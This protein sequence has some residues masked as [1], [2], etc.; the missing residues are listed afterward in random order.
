ML[1]SSQNRTILDPSG[2]VRLGLS[3]TTAGS[4]LSQWPIGV[5]ETTR[6][7]TRLSTNGTGV[8]AAADYD[9]DGKADLALWRSGDSTFYS[10]NSSNGAATTIP[11]GQTGVPVSADYDGDGKADYTL[12]DDSAAYWYVRQSTT[13]S[14]SSIAWG[15]AGEFEK[16][17][18]N[19]YDGDGKVDIAVW[20]NSNGYW[21]IRQSAHAFSTRTVGWGEPGDIPVPAYYRR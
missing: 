19:D 13:A 4:S 7:D 8:P 9:G 12:Y 17:V 1:H 6:S 2:R 3:F 14:I 10:I 20:R 16:P 11:M 15:D 5:T 21:Y 18:H